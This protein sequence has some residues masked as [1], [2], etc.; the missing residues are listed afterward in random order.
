MEETRFHR[1]ELLF[2]KAGQEK[3][4][5]CKVAIVGLGGLGSHVA[6]QLAYL[7][8]G[9]FMLIDRDKASESNLNRL[10]GATDDD[11]ANQA[12]KVDIAH[13][14]IKTIAPGAHVDI[15]SQ[16]FINDDAFALLRTADYVFGCVDND[17]SRLVL[18]ELCQAYSR[19]YVDM[20]TDIDTENNVFGG[21]M[22][23][24]DGRI[25]L[26]CKHL[27]NDEDVRRSFST[28]SQWHDDDRIYGVR[29]GALGLAGPAVVS[30]NGILASLAVTEFMVQVTGVR[31]AYPHLEYKGTMGI[32]ARDTELPDFD[33]YYCKTLRGKGSAADV[34][35]Y[36]REAWGERLDVGE[37]TAENES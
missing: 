15:I 21:R 23:F 37:G 32:V 11:V 30:L 34:E 17:A 9:S 24:S 7:G 3:I 22:L 36:I 29:R 6:Q 19:N 35:R 33:C 26:F 8:V 12:L 16:N 27:L 28:A 20:A 25:C 31:R 10:I 18:N 14:L 5:S 4:E 2:G 1:Q 13:R